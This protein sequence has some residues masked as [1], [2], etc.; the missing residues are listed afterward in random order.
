MTATSQTA[1]TGMAFAVAA[2]STYTFIMDV[3]VSSS[4]GTSPTTTWG[5]TGPASPTLVAIMAEIDTSSTAEI[6]AVL[7][8]F[9]TFPSGA[10]VASSGIR[11]HGMVQTGATAGTVQLTAARGG[12]TPSMVVAAGSNGFWIKTA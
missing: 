8:S 5:F 11:V 12:T 9:S 1:V 7:T 6:S 3:L 4:S 10:Q 2:N